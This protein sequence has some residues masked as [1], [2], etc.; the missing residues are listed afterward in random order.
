M[1]AIT[2]RRV[3]SSVP[4]L[5]GVSILVFAFLHMIPGDPAIT[6]AGENATAQQIADIRSNL[7]LNLPLWKQYATWLGGVI[8]GDLGSSLFSNVHVTTIIS[9]RLPVTLSITGLALVLAVI[10]AVPAAILAATRRGRPT[11]T[12][13]T[14]VTSLGLAIPHFFLGL[15]L[16]LLFAITLGWLPATGYIPF[17][18]S[19]IGW[20]SH[21]ILPAFALGMTAAA[22]LTRQLRGALTET[23]AADYVRTARAKGLR[24]HAVMGHASKNAAIP[25]VTVFGFQVAFLLGGSA[26][27]EKLF[28]IPGVGSLAI[29]SVLRR[30]IPVIQGV[31]LMSALIV[32]ATNL[33]VDLAYRWLNPR[34][35][36]A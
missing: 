20:L 9:Q 3:L 35:R 22:E 14:L 34:M 8:Q 31:V 24:R 7:G 11:D 2:A 29:D 15:L 16:V 36:N 26:I 17:A 1:L 4:I 33:I 6:L 10:V 27:I 12:A 13:I 23:L 21:I 5:V 32:V 28:A 18:V 19:P 30:D 25:A